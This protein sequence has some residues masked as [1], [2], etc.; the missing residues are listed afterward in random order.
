MEKNNNNMEN[1]AEQP[2]EA[3]L[4]EQ[5]YTKGKIFHRKDC[6]NY[7]CGYGI[8]TGEFGKT[9]DGVTLKFTDGREFLS[10]FVTLQKTNSPNLMWDIVHEIKRLNEQHQNDM[11]F[12]LDNYNQL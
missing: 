1:I 9:C 3:Y 8:F 7:D 5:G 6:L 10:D 11:E 4:I 2:K 12:Y